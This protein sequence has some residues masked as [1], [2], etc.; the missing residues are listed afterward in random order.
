MQTFQNVQMIL[1][2]KCLRA[3]EPLMAIPLFRVYL[4]LKFF[5][6][7]AT[8]KVGSH[9][10]NKYY[11]SITRF[12]L[13]SDSLLSRKQHHG[14]LSVNDDDVN[15]GNED[16]APPYITPDDN[17]GNVD[18]TPYR[19]TNDLLNLLSEIKSREL[20]VINAYINA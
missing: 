2:S 19:S 18:A 7:T 13:V 14:S 20:N 17:N 15:N 3:V 6:Q 11:F 9:K 5:L 12:V 4:L 8:P 16:E 10:L 1:N